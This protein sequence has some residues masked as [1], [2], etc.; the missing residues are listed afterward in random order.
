M[1]YSK[2]FF[3]SLVYSVAVLQSKEYVPYCDVNREFRTLEEKKELFASRGIE[4]GNK[5]IVD[6]AKFYELNHKDPARLIQL[7]VPVYSQ[8]CPFTKEIEMNQKPA[9]YLKWVSFDI[10]YGVFADQNIASGTFLGVYTGKLRL[11]K[12]VFYDKKGLSVAQQEVDNTDY[13]WTYPMRAPGNFPL[14][15]DAQFVGNELA[16]VNFSAN[17]NAAVVYFLHKGIFMP[18]YIAMRDIMANEEI[19]ID[20]GGGYCQARNIK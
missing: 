15:I 14:L 20:Y 5:I 12:P 2:L 3:L 1:N 6:Y 17:A 8:G 11:Y 9:I 10:G 7:T 13:A 16:F 18:C 4:Y 19:T